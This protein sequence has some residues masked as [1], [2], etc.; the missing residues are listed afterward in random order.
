MTKYERY[1]LNITQHNDNENVSVSS[2]S[3]LLANL[4]FSVDR[5]NG[6]SITKSE[7]ATCFSTEV[8]AAME[9]VLRR[10]S[11]A[12]ELVHK[13]RCSSVLFIVRM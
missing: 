4:T 11:T 13:V 5:I 7:G 1:V 8:A 10:W 9:I 2:L 12:F 6:I 3:T